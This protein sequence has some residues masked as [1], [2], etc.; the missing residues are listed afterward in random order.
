MLR[1]CRRK[2][3]LWSTLIGM[4]EYDIGLSHSCPNCD[5]VWAPSRSVVDSCRPVC[6]ERVGETVMATVVRDT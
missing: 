4:L 5:P 2:I 1:D 3:V 6:N